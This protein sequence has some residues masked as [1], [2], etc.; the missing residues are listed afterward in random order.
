[1]QKWSKRLPAWMKFSC[2]VTK[3]SYLCV[4]VNNTI[5]MIYMKRIIIL[6]LFAVCSLQI[7]A[8][9]LILQT[10]KSEAERNLAELKKLPIPAYYISYRV[11]DQTVHSI[12]ASFGN[13]MQSTPYQQR[14]FNAAVR[15]GNPQ[16]D[17]THEIKEG[18]EPGYADY[19]FAGYGTLGLEDNPE[20]WKTT[21]WQ[22]TDAMYVEA[23]KRYEKVKAN[24]AVKVSSED[25][26]PDFS[27]ETPESYVEKP[28][29]FSDAKFD[30]KVWEEK[31]KKISAIFKE[32]EDIIDSQCSF[33]IELTHK[34]FVDTEGAEIF[35]N[36][37]CYRLTMSAA[38]KAD[39][40][41]D[42]P[43]YKS[44]FAYDLKDFPS[45]EEI[46]KDA[47]WT[48][49]TLSKLRN[50]PVVESYSGPV[51][52]SGQAAS[53]FFHE[54]F[55]HRI[56]GARLK[57]E[58][59]A[60]TFKKKVGEMVL[61]QDMSVIFE[62][63][64]KNAF[65]FALSGQYVFDDEGVRGKRV[66]VVKEGKLNAFL[67]SRSPIEGF[68]TSN[69]HGR[70]MIQLN[71]FT[72]QSNLMIE[73]NK[74]KSEKELRSM[75][76]TQLKAEGKEYGY[77]M[78]QVSGGFTTTG[79]YMP[80]AFNVSPYLVYRIYADGRPDEIVRGVDLVGTP[81]AIFSQIA[82]CGDD[83]AI[84]NG[85]CGAESGSVPAACVAPTLYVKMVET[86]K[87]ARSQSQPPILSRPFIALFSGLSLIAQTDNPVISA[88]QKEVERNKM[89]LK[90][91]EMTMPFFISYSV[92][93]T[94]NY[95]LT[96]S[97]GTINSYSELHYRR[98]M[99]TL[100]VGSYHRNNL[101]LAERRMYQTPS[102]TSL[103]DN[104]GIPITIWRDLDGAYKTAVEQYRTKMAIL[105]QQTQPDEEKNLPDFEQI[106]PVVMVLD[107]IPVDFDR[108]Y[109][110]NYVRKVS[111]TAKSYPAI[112]QSSVS[113]TARNIMTYTYNTEGSRYAAPTVYYRLM[114]VANTRTDDGQE[115]THTLFA[116]HSTLTQMP[117]LTTF[118]NQCKTMMENL[119]E[120][121][122]A[123]LIDDAYCGPV[124]IEGS[125]VGRIFEKILYINNRLSAA[126]KM[127]QP[128]NMYGNTSMS[129]GNDFELMLN[130]KVI[131]RSITVKSITGQEYYKGERLN[132]YYPI[133]AEGVVPDKELVLIENGVLRQLLNGRKPTKKIGNSNGHTRFDFNTNTF[134]V[135]PGNILI[136]SNQTFSNVELYKKLM[137]AAKEEDLDYAYIVRQYD[138]G[139]NMMY[140]IYIE[141]GREELVRGATITDDTNLKAF[142]RILG[143]SD[144]EFIGSYGE[145]QSTFIF[146]RALL[147]EEMD[148]TRI[149]NI[150]F[151]KPYMVSKP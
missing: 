69:G 64:L 138:N 20:A 37:L 67:M 122:N 146:P 86:Q 97:L 56:E 129:G 63:Q 36:R 147:F 115:L 74:P 66:E 101:N 7:K 124:L 73:S 118:A 121:K 53:V 125:A 44:Y 39:D 91:G 103:Y 40:G 82:A 75:M 141:D 57:N 1:M 15:V 126:P 108:A 88:I 52:M 131:S 102:T 144:Q 62:P 76:V 94:Y 133:D 27:V 55:G 119:I 142:K 98:G 50:A 105:Q 19:N 132:G 4:L 22:K 145:L 42:L 29:Q 116:E 34:Y 134:R 72:R 43:L 28:I 106:S 148:I 130:K 18:N 70:G 17:N 90:M 85:Y 96:A 46:L 60:Q 123:P 2:H 31:L 140:R 30:A 45:D 38:A 79:R 112:L 81:L 54:I 8:Q 13:I 149:P 136:T 83:H 128:N 95:Q 61:P 10:L 150:E 6:L 5:I 48:S 9:G 104:S 47:K 89:D 111:E 93:D 11:Y 113:L 117:D 120:L 23:T 92:F 3:K 21:L 78:D 49:E 51:L 77:L 71:T 80:N 16:L 59:D 84:F 107:A 25:Q 12:S 127:V 137:E 65:G 135:V 24:V 143:A 26:S 58:S 110:E 41:M 139:I 32:N 151:K 87:K 109:W 68:P 33:Q 100:L 114:F 35:E 14:L 99:P